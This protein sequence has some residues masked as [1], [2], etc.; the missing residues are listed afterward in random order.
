MRYGEPTGLLTVS[1]VTAN[2]RIQG[3]VGAQFGVGTE[4]NYQGNLVPLSAGAAYEE[5]PTISYTPVQGEAYLRQILSP[6]PLDLTLLVLGASGNSPQAMTLLVKS[7][8]GIQNPLF[9]N[10]P[11][12]ADDDRFERVAELLAALGRRGNLI[13]TQE[14]KE[15]ARI[16]L[17]LRGTGEKYAQTVGELHTL[18]GLERPNLDG[19]VT[20]PVH[21]GIVEPGTPAIELQTRSMYDLLMI[22]AATV[23][24]PP[25][26]LEAGLTRKLP[27]MGRVGQSMRIRSSRQTPE[28]AM[29]AVRHHG[30]WFSIDA[31][32][33]ESKETF[34]TIKALMTVRMADTVDKQASPVLTLGVSR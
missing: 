25:E 33:A 3:N 34:R 7:I 2:M 11:S 20:L 29:A 31:A 19:D 15:D 32:D 23:D 6:L 4:S 28:R 27:P 26:D 18:L 21:L 1:S 10:D 17:V 24:V 13:W 5:N 9:L 22:A 16:T 12:I 14:P 8:N 30:W